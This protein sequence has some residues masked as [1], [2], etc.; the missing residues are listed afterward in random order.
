MAI[1][2]TNPSH[3]HRP[4]TLTEQLSPAGGVADS[5][6][7]QLAGEMALRWRSGE[8]PLAEEYLARH[9]E[10]WKQPNDALRLIY[11]EICLRQERGEDKASVEVTQRFPQWQ[12]KLEDILCHRL[13]PPGQ[14]LGGEGVRG[15]AAGEFLGGF[16]LMEEL[17]QGIRGRVFLAAEPA[18]A[19]RTVVLKITPCDGREHLSLA[20]LQHTHI[21]PLYYVQDHLQRNLRVLCMPYFGGAA[22]SQLLQKLAGKL[23]DALTGQDLL[24]ALDQFQRPAS[25]SS[26][27]VG[28][29]R[30][31]GCQG[32]IRLFLSQASFVQAVCWIASCL[33]DALHYAHE[34][35]LVHLDLKPSNVLLAADGQPM[36][37]DFHLAQKPLHPDGPAPEWLGGTPAYMSLEQK[38]AFAAMREN[39]RVP[40]AVDGRSDIYSLG[41]ILYE[42]LG[43]SP[44]PPSLPSTLRIGR[45]FAGPKGEQAETA[46]PWRLDNPLVT[47]SLKDLIVKCLREDPKERYPNAAALAADLRRYLSDLPLQGVRNR[48]FAERWHKW[49]RRR[50][51]ALRLWGLVLTLLLTTLAAAMTWLSQQRHGFGNGMAALRAGQDQTAVGHYDEAVAVLQW[52]LTMTQGIP[53]TGDLRQELASN[54]QAA[55]EKQAAQEFHD[56]ADRIRLRFTADSLARKAMLDLEASCRSAW[57]GRD[58]LLKRLKDL[59]PNERVRMQTDMLDLAILSANLRVQLAKANEQHSAR[60][61]ALQMLEEAE[62]LFGPSPGLLRE[63]QLYAKALGLTELERRTSESVSLITPRNAW[64][65]YSLGRSYLYSGELALAAAEFQKAVDLEPSGLWPNYYKAL[66]AFR[67]KQYDVARVAFSVCI[68]AAAQNASPQ[69]VAKIFYNRAL[70]G[71][72]EEAR[73]DYTHALTLDPTLGVAAF[74]RGILNFK[75]KRYAKAIHDLKL[76]LNNGVEPAVV[77]FHL[78][79]VYEAQE[80]R[81]AAVASLRRALQYEPG[82]KD[83]RLHLNRLEPPR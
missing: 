27:Q 73:A 58:Q 35:G 3:S 71:N 66:C 79:M 14:P 20:R 45:P 16:R 56:L 59:A 51:T 13:S 30:V 2:P 40:V 62:A 74:N 78:A 57:Q 48:N 42:A 49:R 46:R 81:P 64:E 4:T 22:L 28:E 82:H 83:A 1:P 50:P 55:K 47:P 10:L 77:Y 33:A 54:L 68:G 53:F 5:L 39:R 52:G 7:A 29:D 32:P 61:S 17:G 67:L 34:R 60:Q 18:L 9:P 75:E 65:H 38:A 31:G 63:R 26:S 70:A 6:V 15:I 21:V 23:L 12:Q 24:N 37:L 11:E 41:V 76:A 80:D 25:V 72:D 43:G 8:S 36:L 69:A 19:D 44:R